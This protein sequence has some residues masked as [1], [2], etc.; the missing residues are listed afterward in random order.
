M[1]LAFAME[2]YEIQVK[3]GRHFLHEHPAGASSWRERCVQKVAGMK[4]VGL[5][6]AD[7]CAFGLTTKCNDDPSGRRLAKKPTKFMSS[8]LPMLNRLHLLCTG[9]HKHQ[10]LSGGRAAEAAV[11]PVALLTAIVRVSGTPQTLRRLMRAMLK[12]SLL[13]L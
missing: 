4:G 11:Y 7:Q 3:A 9:D 2:L 1:H 6:R 10:H 13:R 8:S 12:M 5:I